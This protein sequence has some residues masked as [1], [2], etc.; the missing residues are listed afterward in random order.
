MLCIP[1]KDAEILKQAMR[2]GEFTL[3]KLS[4]MSEA[5]MSAIFSRYVGDGLGKFLGGKFKKAFDSNRKDSLINLVGEVFDTKE[6]QE[7]ARKKI[8][9]ATEVN[10]ALLD[11]LAAVREGYGLSDE[12]VKTLIEKTQ[13]IKD[14][15]S[16]KTEL[17]LPTKEYLQAYNEM[18]K[19]VQSFT[20]TNNLRILTSLMGRT[21][22]LFRPSSIMFNIEGNTINSVTNFL[23]KKIGYGFKGG[24]NSDVAKEFIKENFGNYIDTGYD[25]TRMNEL[26]EGHKIL[27]EEQVHT[28]GSGFIRKFIGKYSKKF[29]EITQGAPDVWFA[30]RAFANTADIHSTVMARNEG[31]EGDELK[32]RAK[33]IMLDSFQM[34]PETEQGKETRELAQ[35]DA[36]YATYTNESKASKLA[37]GIR[38]LFNDLIPNLRLGDLNIPFA[39]TPANV[40][41]QG[42]EM[43]GGAT[44]KVGYEL[45]KFK[46]AW[47]EFGKGSPEAKSHMREAVRGLSKLGLGFMVASLVASLVDEDD[48]IGAYPTTPSEQ[49]LFEAR[50]GIENS[51]R[52]GD[53]WVSVGYLGPFAPV[54]L[55]RL[56]AK[57]YAKNEGAIAQ[58]FQYVRGAGAG[59][60]EIP[61]IAQ[62]YDTAKYLKEVAQQGKST[63]E[64]TTDAINGLIDFIRSRT[65]PGIISD[66][67]KATDDYERQ[68]NKSAISKS[69]ASIP[70]LREN[71]P[72]KTTVFGKKIETESALSIFLFGSRAKTAEE[73]GVINE[74]IDLSN[75]GNLPSLSDVEKSSTRVKTFKEQVPVSQ[76]N[77]AM[78]TFKTDFY[79]S[80]KNLIRTNE[81]RTAD[82]ETKAKM[83]ND[84]KESTLTKTLNAFGYVKPKAK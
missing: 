18:E 55:G 13:K 83:I 51:I 44:A 19:Y 58:I 24:L 31:L 52:I 73:N 84:L 10:D 7:I 81:Y 15:S 54:I 2:D 37:L 49:K 26:A 46:Q 45:V 20:P 39:K 29:L 35:A 6:K 25:F 56:Y 43:S 57:K 30:S 47:Q 77:R 42:I 74:L 50:N 16:E 72:V 48:F 27:T 12:Q 41:S 71:L 59:V 17:G 22:M 40:I 23:E 34:Q 14:L 28:E 67:A 32:A 64:V 38:K 60:L 75:S 70:G 65:I 80:T 33:E 78:S 76:Y 1:K 82:D 9:Q 62:I 69:Q 79:Q 66:I 53:K 21:M 68:T 11:D 8:E 61:G 3:A 5:E 63:G 36:A 4:E